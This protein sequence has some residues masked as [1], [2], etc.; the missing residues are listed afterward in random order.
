MIQNF[1]AGFYHLINQGTLEAV[2]DRLGIFRDENILLTYTYSHWHCQ[3]E[4]LEI[5]N[6]AIEYVVKH[7]S[8]ICQKV[9]PPLSEYTLLLL[10][11][12]QNKKGQWAGS[13]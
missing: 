4:N 3:Q 13:V 9:Y 2:I 1:K 11:F 12:G 7:S 10:S 8:F 5:V 6:K